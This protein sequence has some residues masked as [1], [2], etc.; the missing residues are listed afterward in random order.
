M[1]PI[2]VL[3]VFGIM[4]RAG[5]ET[6]IMN[7]Y[8]KIDRK[9][10]QFDFLVYKEEEGDF[11]EEILKMGGKIYKVPPIQPKTFLQYKKS[12]DTF[13]KSHSEYKI[14]H[15]HLDA[16]STMPLRAAKNSNI[17]I[18]ISH[19]HTSN[20]PVNIK[21]AF[22]YYSKLHINKNSTHRFACS[23]NAMLWLF[24]KK[25][26][27]LPTSQIINNGIDISI[28]EYDKSVRS[29][30][31]QEL[32]IDKELIIGLVGKFTK[33]KNH[34]FLIDI[35]KELLEKNPDAILILVG[36]GL[37]EQ[38]IRN[39]V[40]HFKME[41]NVKFLGLRE[42]VN[43]IMQAI[44]VLVQPSL[45]EGFPVTLVEAQAMGLPSVV[46]DNITKEVSI[47]NLISF[48]NLDA[49]KAKWVNEILSAAENSSRKENEIILKDE[50]NINNVAKKLENF[51]LENYF[52]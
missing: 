10:I 21:A 5:A 42:D 31:R 49:P 26:A 11:D 48:V 3:Q 46:S 38:D 6:F 18:R 47:S 22:R 30:V 50:F 51:Y 7:V 40:K 41:K 25:H 34:N 28:F 8:R 32:G 13:F 43:R 36:S 44:D 1:Y 35:F 9:K 37:L 4:N 2:R 12:L 29:E 16:L 19:S 23:E 33:T 14:V 15:S 27:K 24:G 52:N 20:V 45:H 39:K 17:P